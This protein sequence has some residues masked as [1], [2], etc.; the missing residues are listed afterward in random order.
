MIRKTFAV[1]ALSICAALV[2]VS[3]LATYFGS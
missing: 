2:G 1:A 3:A